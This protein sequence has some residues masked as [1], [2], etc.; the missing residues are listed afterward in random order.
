MTSRSRREFLGATAISVVAPALPL[1]ASPTNASDGKVIQAEIERR[2][3]EGVQHLQE[4]IRQPSIAAE[5]RG[6]AEG[7]S[8]LAEELNEARTK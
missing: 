8:A 6:M 4:W 3:A 1:P 5:N 7:M 2:H